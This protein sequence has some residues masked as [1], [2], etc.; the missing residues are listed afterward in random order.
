MPDRLTFSAT[1]DYRCPFARNMHAGIIAGLRADAPWDVTFRP[2]LLDQAHAEEGELPVWERPPEERGTGLLALTWGLAV[3]DAFPSHFLSFHE[4]LFAARFESAE[5]IQ[6]EQVVRGVAS[7]VG[8]DPDEVAA[9]VTSEEPLATLAR[10][11]NQAVKE[12]EAF[13][14]PTIAIDDRAVFVRLMDPA[15]PDDVDRVL[16]LTRWSS[17]NE[18]K[19]A[20]L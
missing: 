19:H 11:H 14:V 3:R 12:W 17:L 5:K 6:S 10:E 8:L 13:G 7:A 9:V 20:H 16:T 4:A 1:W 2:F 15:T 18:F